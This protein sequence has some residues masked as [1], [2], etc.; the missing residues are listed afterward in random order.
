[1]SGMRNILWLRAIWVSLG[2]LAVSTVANI[3]VSYVVHVP[4][5]SF[6]VSVAT[7]D[8][9]LAGL[10]TWWYLKDSALR[11]SAKSGFNFGMVVLATQ[12]LLGIVLGVVYELYNIPP[13]ELSANPLI[14]FISIIVFTL[15]TTSVVGA[16]VRQSSTHTR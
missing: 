9:A 8:I 2:V 10:A 16:L 4:S 15:S 3:G 13:I 7:V 12:F 14:M 6:D 11:A 5:R 1:M